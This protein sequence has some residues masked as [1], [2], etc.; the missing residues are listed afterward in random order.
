MQCFG[1]PFKPYCPK[2]VKRDTYSNTTLELADDVIFPVSVYRDTLY[3]RVMGIQR[4][5]RRLGEDEESEE[6]EYSDSDDEAAARAKKDT[7]PP[8]PPGYE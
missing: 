2:M 6:S 8:K 5:L 4:A 3:G 1:I 7:G